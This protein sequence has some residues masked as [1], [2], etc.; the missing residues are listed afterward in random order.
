MNL[1]G[2]HYKI[3]LLSQKSILLK[4]MLNDEQG[5]ITAIKALKKENRFLKKENE[6]LQRPYEN[7]HT[8]VNDLVNEK[9][10]LQNKS[11]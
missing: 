7:L 9:T 2:W 10:G 5:Y 1:K 4:V 6:N 8:K 11:S 3:S